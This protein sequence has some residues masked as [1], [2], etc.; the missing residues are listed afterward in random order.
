MNE[1][2]VNLVNQISKVQEQDVNNL[3]SLM[4]V[5]ESIISKQKSQDD[6][7]KEVTLYLTS[8]TKNLGYVTNSLKNI[9]D[10]LKL[11]G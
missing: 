3:A 7:N 6:F 4:T 10:I 9:T 2:L 1:E 5:I 11:K 8:N